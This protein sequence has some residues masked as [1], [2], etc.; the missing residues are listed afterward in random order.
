MRPVWTFSEFSLQSYSRFRGR[1]FFQRCGKG[2]PPAADEVS[3]NFIDHW[4]SNTTGHLKRR[5]PSFRSRTRTDR[6]TDRM[7]YSRQLDICEWPFPKIHPIWRSGASLSLKWNK[8]KQMQMRKDRSMFGKCMAF[9]R[10]NSISITLPGELVG[11][12][13]GNTLWFLLGWCSC[14][15]TF[16]ERRRPWDAHILIFCKMFSTRRPAP[17]YSFWR[18]PKVRGGWS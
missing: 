11:G 16:T 8:M 3:V 15:L 17:F 10:C 9:F 1:S 2:E 18:C 13:L 5:G 4:T 14:L 7:A 6:R 12:P